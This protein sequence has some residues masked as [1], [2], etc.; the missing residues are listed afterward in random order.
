MF[1]VHLSILSEHQV[2]ILFFSRFQI[3]RETHSPGAK[4]KSMCS[5]EH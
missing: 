1:G 4:K 3:W 5:T 2:N